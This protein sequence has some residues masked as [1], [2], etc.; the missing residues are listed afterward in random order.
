MLNKLIERENLSFKESYELFNMLLNESEMRI[1]AYLVA[2]QTK[3]VTADEIAGFAKA[4]RD[5]AVKIDLGEVTD[6][7]GTGGD[8]S[9]TINVSTAVS[10]ILAC[11]TKVAKHGNVSITS[12]SGS[13]NVYEALGCKIP[14][15][16]EDAK[17]SMDKTNFVF[18]FAQKYHPALKKIMPV[19][20]ELKVKTIFNILGPLANPANP[21]YQ[22][23]GVN[24]AELCE[25][26]AFALSKVGGIK[27]ALL[28]YGNGLDELTPN[29]TSKITEYDGKFDTYEV[30]PKDF[31][32]DYS[33]IIPCESP[34]ESA[35]RLI[36]VFSGK[37]NEDRNFILMN[38]AAA[39]YTS[40]IASDFL[41]GVEIAKEAIESGKVLKKLEEI[42]NV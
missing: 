33:K 30:T 39:L 4:M 34:D 15:T 18:L 7:C 28:V 23:L 9:K 22:I 11:F 25:N 26:V 19:R 32:L 1:A 27:K 13:A 31:G 2:L 21:K 35:K 16:P 20:N 5:N 40:E 41:D 8:G 14:E 38:A 12:N 29:G 17:K 42:R 37:I 24:S 3:G 6:T 36:D 10:I